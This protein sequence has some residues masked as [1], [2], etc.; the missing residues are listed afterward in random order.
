MSMMKGETAQMAIERLEKDLR[1]Q[2]RKAREEALIDAAKAVCDDCGGRCPN[3][4]TK[5]YGPN[6]A[7]NYVHEEPQDVTGKTARLCKATAIW[8]IIYWERGSAGLQKQ[9]SDW[10]ICGWCAGTGKENGGRICPKC[11]GKGGRFLAGE[12]RV[13]SAESNGNCARC[14]TP[15][16]AGLA[17]PTCATCPGCKREI[18]PATCWCGDK[19]DH[20][21]MDGHSGVPQGCVCNFPKKG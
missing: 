6:S 10:A 16:P 15:R 8:S 21:Y 7:A 5:A 19:I 4:D 17:C 13:I 11:N 18:D 14:G 2:T 9:R 12:F 3:Y 1:L 20:P